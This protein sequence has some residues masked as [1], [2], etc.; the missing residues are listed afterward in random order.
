MKFVFGAHETCICCASN[1]LNIYIKYL[2]HDVELN[3]SFYLCY[4]NIKLK[5]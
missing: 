5:Y 2:K 4:S 1:K 3:E